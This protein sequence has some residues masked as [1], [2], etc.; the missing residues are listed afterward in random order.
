MQHPH[1]LKNPN[2][3][4]RGRFRLNTVKPQK[5]RS[6]SGKQARRSHKK[7]RKGCQECKLRRIKCD[8]SQ[9]SCSRCKAHRIDCLYEADSTAAKNAMQSSSSSDEDIGHPTLDPFESTL[10]LSQNNLQIRLLLDLEGSDG[11][12]SHLKSFMTCDIALFQHFSS[13]TY[14]S[15][16]G[17]QSE[18]VVKKHVLPYS[19]TASSL[20][21]SLLALSARHLMHLQPDYKPHQLS[22]NYH[23]QR[24]ASLLQAQLVQPLSPSNIDLVISNC[25]FINITSIVH[26]ELDPSTSFVMKEDPSAVDDGLRWLN[27]QGSVSTIFDGAA[28]LLLQSFWLPVFQED[29]PEISM[30]TLPASLALAGAT[31]IPQCLASI[32]DITPDSDASSNDYHLALRHLV[33]V[34]E[35]GIEIS[36][37][38]YGNLVCFT[39]RMPSRFRNLLRQKDERALLLFAYWLTLI[40]HLD[41]W[42]A[43]GRTRNDCTAICMV[44]RKSRD[45]RIRELIRYPAV[46]HGCDIC[47]VVDN[48]NGDQPLAAPTEEDILVKR[49]IRDHELRERK[50][51]AQSDRIHMN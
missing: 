13:C 11:M 47:N 16:A 41:L 37:A 15:L 46:V 20:M 8:E 26:D 45:R 50:L 34:T 51:K 31:G 6:E 49:L 23:I 18:I 43:Q 22:Y 19:T 25:I 12:R 28:D 3:N 36:W 48:D 17:V 9:P 29:G 42:W 10:S 27:M 2:F 32:C 24:A 38:S 5:Q 7:S 35:G 21:H 40:R 33:S 14:K 39:G 1:L 4:G 44:L 30:T